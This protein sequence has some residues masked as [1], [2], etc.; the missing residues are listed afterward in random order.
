MKKLTQQYIS[1]FQIV[2]KVDWLAYKLDIPNDWTIHPIFSVAQLEPAPNLT[3]DP[4]KCLRPQQTLL[5]FVDSDSDKHKSFDIDR[6]FNKWTIQKGRRL[7][8][9]YLVRKTGYSPE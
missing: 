6:P 3:K 2:E 1:P 4:F 8:V 9:E 7:A 5:V